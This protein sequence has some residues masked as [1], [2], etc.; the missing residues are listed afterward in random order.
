[1]AKIRKAMTRIGL[2]WAYCDVYELI[3]RIKDESEDAQAG[4]TRE[5]VC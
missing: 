5:G 3:M 2:N 1:M 4:K